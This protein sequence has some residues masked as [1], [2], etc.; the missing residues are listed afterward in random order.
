MDCGLHTMLL[1]MLLT[2]LLDASRRAG[3]D[4]SA[5]ATPDPSIIGIR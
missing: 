4:E 5:S 3:I 1:A 2:M